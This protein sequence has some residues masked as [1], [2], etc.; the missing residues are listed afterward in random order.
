MNKSDLS[1]ADRMLL[2]F[3]AANIIAIIQQPS[4]DAPRYLADLL[5]AMESMSPKNARELRGLLRDR[6]ILPTNQSE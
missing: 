3:F 2:Q 5:A 1:E 6:G 4:V